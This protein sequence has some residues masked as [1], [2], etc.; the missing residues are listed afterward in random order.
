MVTSYFD[1]VTLVS[2]IAL[3]LSIDIL[4]PDDFLLHSIDFM[5]RKTYV[6]FCSL[7]LITCQ[8]T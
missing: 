3:H 5:T 8:D 1:M 4:S 7:M 6:K 2:L